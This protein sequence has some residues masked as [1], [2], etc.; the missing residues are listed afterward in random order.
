MGQRRCPYVMLDRRMPAL[1]WLHL[2]HTKGRRYLCERRRL[3]PRGGDAAQRYVAL[4]R[5][6]LPNGQAIC[7][8]SLAVRCRVADQA[9]VDSHDRHLQWRTCKRSSQ[10]LCSML[11]PDLPAQTRRVQSPNM[12]RWKVHSQGCRR[13]LCYPQPLYTQLL[14]ARFSR[15]AWVRLDQPTGHGYSGFTEFA[16]LKPWNLTP[17]MDKASAPGR[18]AAWCRW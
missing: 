2:Q 7:A 9:A 17:Y 4:W 14:T 8:V 1:L 3:V 6:G 18:W 16:G 12:K 10:Y 5:H 11:L 15:K 13:D